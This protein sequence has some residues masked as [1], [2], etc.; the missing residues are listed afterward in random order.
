VLTMGQYLRPT[1]HHLP[2]ARWVEPEAFERYREWG[3]ARGFVEVASGP[4]V[5]SSYRADR[6]L[7]GNN[8]GL[9]GKPG[10]GG[11]AGLGEEVTMDPTRISVR[12]L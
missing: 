8:L 5:R 12:Q 3:L 2:V 4:L 7:D 11:H 10:A 1:A 9:G 6:I